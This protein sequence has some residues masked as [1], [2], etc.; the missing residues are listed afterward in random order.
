ME[1]EILETEPLKLFGDHSIGAWAHSIGWAHRIG[2]GSLGSTVFLLV[3]LP[4]AL[5]Q[6]QN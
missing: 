2:V 1:P 4:H 3:F 5:A 6:T